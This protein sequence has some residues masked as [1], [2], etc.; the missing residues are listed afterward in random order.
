MEGR[1]DGDCCHVRVCVRKRSKHSVQA[2]DTS[3]RSMPQRR[4]PARR[5]ASP[6]ASPGLRD[7]DGAT[8]EGRWDGGC[9]HVRVCVCVRA[10]GRKRSKHSVQAID[11][12]W[13]SMPRRR[14]ELRTY[15][16]QN[17]TCHAPLPTLRSD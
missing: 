15:S 5:G 17:L 4:D 2:I 12:S 13:R 9:C 1:W 3:W 8:V 16:Y 7:T 14:E 11:T 6:G 10:C